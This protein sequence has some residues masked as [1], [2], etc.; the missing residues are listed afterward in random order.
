[1]E[2]EIIVEGTVF[3]VKASGSASPQGFIALFEDVIN[4]ENWSPGCCLIVDFRQ[5]GDF[6]T[7]R[8][9]FKG[10]SS[11][12]S[13]IKRH[14]EDF[15][16]TKIATL[17]RNTMNS[18]VVAGLMGSLNDFYGS[19]IEHDIFIDHEDAIGWLKHS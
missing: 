3:E 5:L 8:M 10:V 4:N 17:L 9:D 1:M 13:F 2:H 19:N 16:G 6:D 11:V 14:G 18:K 15:R 12:A 7:R